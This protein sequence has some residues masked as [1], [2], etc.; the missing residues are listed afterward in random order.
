[1]EG[2]NFDTRRKLWCKV[3]IP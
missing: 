3:K 1:M 2:V